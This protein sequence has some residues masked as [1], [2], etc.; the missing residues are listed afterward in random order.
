MKN[1]AQT[2]RVTAQVVERGMSEASAPGKADRIRLDTSAELRPDF[3]GPAELLLTAFAACTLKNVER[4]SHR[5]TFRYRGAEIE[6]WG[7]RQDKPPR[8]THIHY[9]LRVETDES[10][11]RVDLLARNIARYGTI[12]NTLAASCDVSGEVLAAATTPSP[13]RTRTVT[14]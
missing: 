7:E 2:Y 9:T 12:Y 6:V 1:L 8:F 11:Q 4:M 10:P 13:D 5:L 14:A 3:F